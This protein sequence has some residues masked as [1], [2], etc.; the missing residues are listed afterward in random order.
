[1]PMHPA[2]AQFLLAW[3]EQTPYA[4][5]TD[6][7]FPSFKSQGRVPVSPAVFIADHLRPAANGAGIGYRMAAASACTISGTPFQAGS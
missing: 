4:K 6:F 7:I 1:M 5:E 2:L 3:K